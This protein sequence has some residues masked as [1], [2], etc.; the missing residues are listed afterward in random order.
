MFIIKLLSQHV[1][2]IIMPIIRRTT[3]CTAAY[4]VLHWLCWL[5]LCVAGTRAVCTV[6]TLVLMMMGIIMPEHVEISLIINIRLVTSCWFLSLHPILLLCLCILI[7]YVLFC[8]FCFIVLFSVL[9]VCKCVLYHCHR[10]SAQL[11]ST[12]IS[13]LRYTYVACRVFT[14]YVK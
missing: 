7:I 2:G 5:W 1:S 6:H 8:V 11:L 4:G 12:N 14:K 13:I 9:F 3:V 10:V